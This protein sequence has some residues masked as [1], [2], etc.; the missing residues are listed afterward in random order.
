MTN[1][2]WAGVSVA[3]RAGDVEPNSDGG[4]AYINDVGQAALEGLREA[5]GGVPLRSQPVVKFNG[6]TDD[7]LQGPIYILAVS[8]QVDM[9]EVPPGSEIGKAWRGAPDD[10]APG[11]VL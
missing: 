11:T 5:V 4:R 10:E 9:D 2:Q 1:I 7:P 8:A 3:I 6:P